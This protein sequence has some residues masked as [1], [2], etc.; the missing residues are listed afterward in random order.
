[1]RREESD[2]Q[3]YVNEVTNGIF[4]LLKKDYAPKRVRALARQLALN[5]CGAAADGA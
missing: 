1:M 5:R 2:P 4:S 3:L